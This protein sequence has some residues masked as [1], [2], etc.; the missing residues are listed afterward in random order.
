MD[1]YLSNNT[2][3]RIDPVVQ[4]NLL[5]GPDEIEV[6]ETESKTLKDMGIVLDA[7]LKKITLI[8]RH[9]GIFWADGEAKK[10]VCPLPAGVISI[11]CSK[12]IIS[13]RQ[14]I[15]NKKS[16]KMSVIQEGSGY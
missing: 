15:S 16:I 11:D 5:A 7:N 3:Q 2:G 1:V 13:T 14:F 8:P 6:S 10:D 12:D 9:A 4:C